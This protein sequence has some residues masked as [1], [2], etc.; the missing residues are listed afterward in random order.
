MEQSRYP[1]LLAP[2]M[3]VAGIEPGTPRAGRT[4]REVARC[5]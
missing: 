5:R 4:L 2:V 1:A 3:T